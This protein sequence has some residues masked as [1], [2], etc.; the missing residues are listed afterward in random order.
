V[1]VR[2]ARRR[3]SDPAELAEGLPLDLRTFQPSTDPADYRSH[4]SRVADWLLGQQS[5]PTPSRSGHAAELGPA[6]EL[7][8]AVMTAA[9][10]GVVAWYRHALG[11][12]DSREWLSLPEPPHGDE[13]AEVVELPQ[14]TPNVAQEAAQRPTGPSECGPVVVALH[15]RLR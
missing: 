4:L 10:L 2:R 12:T 3:L 11:C 8:P 6:A 1:T 13:L 15:P 5:C 14:P 9:G 7:A